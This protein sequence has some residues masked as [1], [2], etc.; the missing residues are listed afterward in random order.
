MIGKNVILK[1]GR[2]RAFET[3]EFLTLPFFQSLIFASDIT[4]KKLFG[5]NTTLIEMK[6]ADVEF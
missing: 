4:F 5:K 2:P 3:A 6:S 1:N